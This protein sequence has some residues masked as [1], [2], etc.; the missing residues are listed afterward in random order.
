MSNFT[1]IN[2]SFI[3]YSVTNGRWLNR[4][5]SN[6][7]CVPRPETSVV[8]KYEGEVKAARRLALITGSTI[9]VIALV[10][11]VFALAL[12]KWAGAKHDDEQPSP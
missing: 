8:Q 12:W 5:G 2:Y 3:G 11:L 4:D 10:S 6:W 9:T 1:T 7:R